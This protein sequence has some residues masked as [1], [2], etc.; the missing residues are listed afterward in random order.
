MQPQQNESSL[1]Y[2]P[3]RPDLQLNRK[4]SLFPPP[5]AMPNFPPNLVR[6]QSSAPPP[7]PPPLARWQN[8]HIPPPP[9]PSTTTRRTS[10]PPLQP[11][12]YI[13]TNSYSNPLGIRPA[14]PSGTWKHDRYN[15]ND[16]VHSTLTPTATVAKKPVP[17]G[18][19][20]PRNRN[21]NGQTS[22]SGSKWSATK[23]TAFVA[24]S[25]PPSAPP[26]PPYSPVDGI[27]SVSVANT[28]PA[29]QQNVQ[30][31]GTPESSYTPG[32]YG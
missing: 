10:P 21:V 30:A 17:I 11:L 32:K 27:S 14:A 22:K 16:Q 8:G 6:P 9:L 12:P 4:V 26:I 7:P 2:D 23:S 20:W 15:P 3:A 1:A 13:P 25:N 5:L 29:T 19:G 28:S 31:S 18:S 24:A